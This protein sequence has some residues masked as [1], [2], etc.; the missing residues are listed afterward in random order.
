MIA[1]LVYGVDVADASPLE[2]VSGI[3]PPIL[4]IHCLNDAII[5][6][7]HS[8]RLWKASG[9]DRETLWLESGCKHNRAFENDNDRYYERVLGFLDRA[10][11]NN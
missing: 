3:E 6:Y 4:F 9:Q 7:E 1:K 8:R 10:M 11:E 2:V 5:H